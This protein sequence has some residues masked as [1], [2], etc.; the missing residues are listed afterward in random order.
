MGANEETHEAPASIAPRA[1]EKFIFCL[2]FQRDRK[3]DM[4]IPIENLVY[5]RGRVMFLISTHKDYC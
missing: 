2:K 1:I 3:E 5:F 4:H